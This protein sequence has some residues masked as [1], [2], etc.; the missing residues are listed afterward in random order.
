[1]TLREAEQQRE[2]QELVQKT[3]ELKEGFIAEKEKLTEELKTL[4]EE[5]Q[6]NKVRFHYAAVT[7]CGGSPC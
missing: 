6:T 7:G 2:I 1:M 5:A 4:L 3:T